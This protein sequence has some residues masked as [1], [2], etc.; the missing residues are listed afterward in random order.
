MR[1][2][3]RTVILI[4]VAIA[5][6]ASAATTMATAAS[7]SVAASTADAASCGVTATIPVGAG[8]IGVATDP[9]TNTIYVTNGP[10][11]T[12]SVINGNTNTVTA[13]GQHG[14]QHGVGDRFLPPV[15]SAQA[16]EP[17]SNM[18]SNA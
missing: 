13:R 3:Q 18:P 14:Q 16:I 1:F 12:V 10:A 7:A 11:D 9:K 5:G 2:T 4:T 6:L 17:R 8:P 15:T